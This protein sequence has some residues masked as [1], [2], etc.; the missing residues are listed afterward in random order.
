[1]EMPKPG[2]E[3]EKLRAFE[4]SWVG[5]ETIHPSPWDPE[6]GPATARWTN[7]I[8]L[9]GF[10]A[11]T[12]YVQKRGGQ[13]SYRGH[14]VFGHDA[15][16]AVTR[17]TWFDNMGIMHPAEGRWEADTLTLSN[18]SPM[19]HARYTF[20]FSKDSFTMKIENSQDGKAWSPFIEGTYR[21]A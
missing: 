14:G 18:V 2:P 1:M 16:P 11:V 9:D 7:R 19:G 20:K 8:D 3:H 4:G 5:E 13:V 6:G 17:M 21:K 15:E 10:F 12:D